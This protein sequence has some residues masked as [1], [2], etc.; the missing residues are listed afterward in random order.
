MA[1]PRIFCIGKNYAEH[2]AELAPLGHDDELV[3]FMKP[4]SAIVPLGE[5]IRLPRGRGAVHHEAELVVQLGGALAAPD[6]AL[7][8]GPIPLARALDCVAA[9]T[10]GIDLTLRELQTALKKR[11]APWELAK[12]FDGAAPLGRFVP[13]RGQDLQ[14]LEFTCAVNGALRQHGRTSEMLYP[15]AR[16]IHILSQTWRLAPGDLI[17]TGTPAGVGPLV[18]GDRIELAA[19]DLGRFA[20]DCV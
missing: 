14:A 16:Q 1:D 19:A 9:L 10:L 12:A 2:V 11:G 7:T 3:V 8:G 20:W 17:Y 18:P 15:V 6:A 4:A 5:Q 13:Y